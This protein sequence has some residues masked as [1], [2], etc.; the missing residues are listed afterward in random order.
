MNVAIIGTK[1]MG[2][3]HSNAWLNTPHFFDMGIRPVLKV[4]VGTD[5]A[6]TQALAE[7]WG[8]QEWSTDWREV[9]ARPDIDI[10]D[11]ATPT[12]L[13]H[14]M[15]VAAAEHGKHIFLEKPFAVSLEQARAMLAAAEKAGVVT[16]VNH[17]YRRVP[18]VRLA[19]KLIDDGF[20]GRLFH[21]RSTYLQDWIVDPS[22]PL[23][24]HLRRETAGYGAH[25]DLGSHSVD[26]AR[27]LIGDVAAVTGM[28]ANFITERPLPGAGAATFSAG[29]GESTESGPVTVDDASF[30]IAEF[31]NGVLGSFE[32]SRFAPGRKNYNYFEIYGSEGSIVFNGERMNELQV[33][34]RNDPAYAQGFRTIL[35][36]E[37]GQHD[38]IANWWPPGHLIGYEHE[39]HHGVVD[40]MRAIETGGTIEP[41]FYDGMK[42]MEVLDAAMASARNG[43]K[44]SL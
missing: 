42:E 1:F 26:L 19:K 37:A 8:W 18:A 7:N 10:V 34:S 2:K 14:D 4:V 3:A 9:V 43:Q 36:T 28:T 22:F 16:Y 12:Y 35:A 20:V 30:F 44:V 29:S 6:G 11:I 40:F 31:D 5:P 23:T 24:W 38:Y 13:H 27:Y 25:G 15:A 39:F 21:W 33:F 17:N 32:V 41:N